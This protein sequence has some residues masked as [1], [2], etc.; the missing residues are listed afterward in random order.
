MFN[1]TPEEQLTAATDLNRYL[2]SG[3]YRPRIG[4]TFPLAETAAAHALQEANTLHAA[5]TLNGKIV[6]TIPR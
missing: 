6:I 5:G 4:R 1:A 3:A 2:A